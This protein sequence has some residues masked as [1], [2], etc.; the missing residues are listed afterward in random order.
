METVMDKYEH[1]V[2]RMWSLAINKTKMIC[3]STTKTQW[4]NLSKYKKCVDCLL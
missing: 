3:N 1:R 4:G 2:E